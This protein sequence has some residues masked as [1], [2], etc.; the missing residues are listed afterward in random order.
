MFCV[1]PQCSDDTSS[2][3]GTNSVFPVYKLVGAVVC[4]YHF[5]KQEKYHST[6]GEC[7][8]N[9][10]LAANDPDGSNANNYLVIKYISVRTSGSNAESECALGATCDGGLR[11][12]RLTQ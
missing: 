7:A 4:G 11:R 2:G 10:Y 5:S 9:P 1:Q 8:G 12:T 6:T 3:Q